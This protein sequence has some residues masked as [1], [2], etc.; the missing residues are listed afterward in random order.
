MGAFSSK[1]KTRTYN[2]GR[3]NVRCLTEEMKLLQ[4]EIKQIMRER[5]EEA[6]EYERRVL[7]LTFREAEWKGEKKRLKEEEKRLRKTVEEKEGKI[8]EL[9]ENCGLVRG[10]C[11]LC[12]KGWPLLGSSG[13]C[14][15]ILVEQ[16][17]EER[18]QRDETVEKWKQL[19]LAIK[20]ELDDLIQKTH[21][22]ALYWR[23]E[24]KEVVEELKR[25]VKSKEETIEALEVRLASM[26]REGYERKREID[27][28]RQSLRIMSSK[29]KS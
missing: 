23:A 16:M 17:R 10:K 22:D 27:I 3:K 2:Y 19:Y 15:S 24:G 1:K 25:E 28:L 26:E 6:Q 7:V 9:E 4:D 12:D 8:R 18:A 5:E 21:G 11:V 13:G 14:S 29:K 20:N